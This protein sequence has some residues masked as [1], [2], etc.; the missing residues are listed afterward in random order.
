MAVLR[1]EKALREALGTDAAG[2]SRARRAYRSNEV[3]GDAEGRRLLAAY[4]RF[5]REEFTRPRRFLGLFGW[6]GVC[7]VLGVAGFL[8]AGRYGT[9]L[10]FLGMYL[11]L[12]LVSLGLRGRLRKSLAT[13]ERALAEA[14]RGRA[15]G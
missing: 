15:D 10:F 4:V 1:Q 13:R 11:V 3:P 6:G 14:G 5:Y 2:V 9:A 7:F 8:V 12:A